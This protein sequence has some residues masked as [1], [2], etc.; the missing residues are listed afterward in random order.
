MKH[1]LMWLSAAFVL[2]LVAYMVT[3]VIIALAPIL[4]IIFA[5]AVVTGLLVFLNRLKRWT[6]HK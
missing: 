4:A 5:L 2:V 6:K 1:L 3:V